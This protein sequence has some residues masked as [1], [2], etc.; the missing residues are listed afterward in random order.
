MH[1][2]DI[3]D[4]C[5]F[6][7]GFLNLILVVCLV[8]HGA[9]SMYL[10]RTVCFLSSLCCASFFPSFFH[11]LPLHRSQI[12]SNLLLISASPYCFLHYSLLFLW[13]WAALRIFLP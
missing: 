10:L 12:H 13:I 2:C 3:C 5:L 6:I 9:C 4:I 11:I 7:F 8:V 1:I